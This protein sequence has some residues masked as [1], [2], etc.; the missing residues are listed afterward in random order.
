MFLENFELIF[1]NL[2]LCVLFH[3][4]LYEPCGIRDGHG[5][6]YGLCDHA[7]DGDAPCVL[8]DDH[9]LE[10]KEISVSKNEK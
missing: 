1:I 3:D 9:I 10:E 4:V 2:Q 6:L 8:Y 7:N 5:D